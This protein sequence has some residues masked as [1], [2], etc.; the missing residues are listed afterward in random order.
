MCHRVIL[1]LSDYSFPLQNIHSCP[2][3]TYSP[4]HI[5]CRRMNALFR[6]SLRSS[7]HTHTHSQRERLWDFDPWVT[8]ETDE[9]IRVLCNE[10]KEWVNLELKDYRPSGLCQNTAILCRLPQGYQTTT[11]QPGLCGG[12]SDG[13]CRLQAWKGLSDWAGLL[14]VAGVS[15][16]ACLKSRESVSLNSLDKDTDIHG[17]I[18]YFSALTAR[19]KLSWCTGLQG[20][21]QTRPFIRSTEGRLLNESG[22]YCSAKR[23]FHSI[24]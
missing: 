16:Q 13:G 19:K 22:S 1:L 15:M 9:I 4:Y 8:V 14:S 12:G 2:H 10:M 20:W 11:F 5:Y 23:T 21:P 24:I 18:S 7:I 17:N 3:Y 6:L